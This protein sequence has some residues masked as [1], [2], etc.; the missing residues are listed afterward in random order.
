METKAPKSRHYNN[1]YYFELPVPSPNSSGRR[2][3]CPLKHG[4]ETYSGEN[5]AL[6][7]NFPL[8]QRQLTAKIKEHSP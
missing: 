3:L 6:P 2:D 7:E 4:S 5:N 8:T 1:N